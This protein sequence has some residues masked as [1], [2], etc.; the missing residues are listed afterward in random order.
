MTAVDSGM[1]R[2][3]WRLTS[4]AKTTAVRTFIMGAR[5]GVW[6]TMMGLMST[7]HTV[8]SPK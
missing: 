2:T 7:K 1:R 3:M 6:P 8:I 5:A 4:Q